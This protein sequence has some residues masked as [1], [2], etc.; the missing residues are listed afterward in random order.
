MSAYELPTSVQVGDNIYKITDNGDFRV[1]LDCFSALG[2]AEL[3]VQERLI[4][5]III[6]YDEFDDLESVLVCDDLQ[7][8]VKQMYLFFNC[9]YV[10]TQETQSS[11]TNGR[12]LIDWEADAQLICSAVNKVA[13]EEI[14]LKSYL[15]WW[16]FMGYYMAVDHSLLNIIATI[17][18]KILRGI[19]LE[20]QER[21]FRNE[22]PQYFVWNHKTVEQQEAE[23]WV[24]E[25]WNSGKEVGNATS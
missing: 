24:H 19:S 18:D 21:Q 2:D 10:N 4:S 9:G 14:R 7:E 17:R 22:N 5:C 15:H 16:T 1:I 20:K 6:F 3:S 12:K 23:Q 11:Y 25:I 8:L 13:G